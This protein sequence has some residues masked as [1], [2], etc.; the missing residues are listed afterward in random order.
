M[1]HRLKGRLDWKLAAVGLAL[2]MGVSQTSGAARNAYRLHRATDGWF[3]AG[4]Q[5]YDQRLPA[6][7]R[8][9][10]GNFAGAKVKFIVE[11][12]E[13][14][15]PVGVRKAEK[16]ALQDKVQMLVGGLLAST[17][18]ALAPVSTRLKVLYIASTR[19]RMI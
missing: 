13:A 15:P 16:L 17:G 4:R 12:D 11:D 8:R 1:L 2:G 9:V 14:K 5:G 10:G 3:R 18:Y 6:L 7:P 19:P